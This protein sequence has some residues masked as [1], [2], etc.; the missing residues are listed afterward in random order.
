M[1][2][3]GGRLLPGATGGTQPSRTPAASR[4]A[5]SRPHPR[6]P[7]PAAIIDERTGRGG[8]MKGFGLG[9][10]NFESRKRWRDSAQ[11]AG[12]GTVGIGRSCAGKKP[13]GPASSAATRSVNG[14]VPLAPTAHSCER[15]RWR[16]GE[17]GRKKFRQNEQ[18]ARTTGR[19]ALSSYLHGSSGLNSGGMNL[20]GRLG[21]CEPPGRLS[22]RCFAFGLALVVVSSAGGANAL[23]DP[24]RAGRVAQ[25]RE[26]ID[27]SGSGSRSST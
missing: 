16:S 13:A 11:A 21:P 7:R 25:E 20:A 6:L 3:G 18:K 15:E 9:F 23:Q 12:R 2:G 19:Q 8:K 17:V 27:R 4:P 26:G 10:A 1:V 22:S 14:A 24:V 5:R